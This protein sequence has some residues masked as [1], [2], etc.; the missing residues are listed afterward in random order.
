MSPFNVNFGS[1]AFGVG[2][3]FW[4]SK[5]KKKARKISRAFFS[6]SMQKERR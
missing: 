4:V 6:K 2:T 3:I 1:V 5:H